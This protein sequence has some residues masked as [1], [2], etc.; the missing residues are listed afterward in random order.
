MENA[1]GLKFVLS[2]PVKIDSASPLVWSQLRGS[3]IEKEVSGQKH[4]FEES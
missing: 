4:L 2:I 3:G 1:I